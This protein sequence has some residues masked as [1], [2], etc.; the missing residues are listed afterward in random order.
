MGLKKEG[1][2]VLRK[3]SVHRD[4][5]SAFFLINSSPIIIKK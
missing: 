2:K 3:A 4:T 5:T 1:S